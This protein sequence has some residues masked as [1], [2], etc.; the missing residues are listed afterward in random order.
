MI[1]IVFGHTIDYG[2]WR[3]WV[4]S[5]HV[6]LFFVLSGLT[7][8]AK[9]SFGQYCAS[10]AKR[11]L[12]PYCCFGLV[13]IL[14]FLVAGGFAASVLGKEGIDTSFAFNIAGLIYGNGKN[15][16]MDFNLPL[17][18]L[19]CMF[20]VCLLAYPVVWLVERV[21]KKGVLLMGALIMSVF[22]SY[23]ITL[24]DPTPALPFSL[25][26]A[27]L[28][29]PFLL[30]GA[31]LGRSGWV[32]TKSQIK[33]VVGAAMVLIGAM[34]AAMNAK[35]GIVDYVATACRSYPLFFVAAL[36]QSCGL[37][38]IISTVQS[39]LALAGIGRKT[40]SV[41]VIHK[42]PIILFQIL[43]KGV[44]LLGASALS[45]PFVAL[46]IT[47]AVIAICLAAGCVIEH[48]APWAFGLPKKAEAAERPFRQKGEDSD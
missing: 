44:M 12:M 25:E 26:N 31:I 4:Y 37:I 39:S 3:T 48:V 40:M 30:T 1:A 29:M 13:S 6:P 10:K 23:G 14:V 21:R 11:L 27:V 7:L 47:L 16:M 46:F 28:L 8:Y 42:F 22:A 41:L 2:P 15:G 38:A 20:A 43:L 45:N 34:A 5:F 17:W 19:P 36:L 24:I 9:G 35:H 33:I 32:N 18:F